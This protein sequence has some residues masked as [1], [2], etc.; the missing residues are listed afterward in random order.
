MSYPQVVQ[1]IPASQF[2]PI[3]QPVNQ[4]NTRVTITE[5]PTQPSQ[6]PKSCKPA[7]TEHIVYLVQVKP[8]W[9]IGLC[10]CCDDSGVC[11]QGVLCPCL[12]Y[13]KLKKRL[14]PESSK[15]GHCMKYLFCASCVHPGTRRQVRTKYNLPA[16]P[17]NDCCV[18]FFC[19]P[20]ALCQE[21]QET[22]TEHKC[23]IPD[24]PGVQQ[25]I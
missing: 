6:P 4:L 19:S 3:V 12:L 2:Q 25:M 22:F 24:S 20:C 11:I 18:G 23:A 16:R 5:G 21:Y 7:P 9:N 14:H 8:R 15:C 10:E 1:M 13:S 17:C